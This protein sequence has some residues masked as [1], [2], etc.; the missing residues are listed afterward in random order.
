MQS[1]DIKLPWVALLLF[2]I[3]IC[4]FQTHMQTIVMRIQVSIE[5]IEIYNKHTIQMETADTESVL[6]VKLCI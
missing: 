3:I 1:C 6:R 5:S 2:I 4:L